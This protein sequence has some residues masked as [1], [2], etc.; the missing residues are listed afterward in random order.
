MKA[1]SAQFQPLEPDGQE[2]VKRLL[3]DLNLDPETVKASDDIIKDQSQ[4]NFLCTRCD[5]RV[6]RYMSFIDLVGHYLEAKKWFDG[7]TK[8]VRNSPDSCYPSRAVNSELPKIVNDHDWLSHDTLLVRQ[9][10]KETKDAVKQLQD[11]FR[12][13]GLT[14]PLCDTKGIGGEDLEKN[15][16]REILRHDKEPNLEKDTTL[17]RIYSENPCPL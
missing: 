16:W 13:A 4:K 11:D 15:R 5:E 6:A 12:K 10:D 9:D 2:L 14:D 17:E 8:A 1:I 3:N 7:V